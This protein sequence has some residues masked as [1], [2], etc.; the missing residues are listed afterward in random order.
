M[1]NRHLG[2]L[3]SKLQS[4]VLL[5]LTKQPTKKS[6]LVNQSL[7]PTSALN[8]K[9]QS[10]LPNPWHFSDKHLRNKISQ[11]VTLFTLQ[12]LDSKFKFPLH[13]HF[14]QRLNFSPIFSQFFSRMCWKVIN[15]QMFG[16]KAKHPVV[17]DGYNPKWRPHTENFVPN[18]ATPE[19]VADAKTTVEP[20]KIAFA[21]AALC[22]SSN[23]NRFV[24]TKIL[25][26]EISFRFL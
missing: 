13:W 5:L 1:S 14:E 19:W 11:K 9:N 25:K 3:R 20:K 10:S 23:W 12:S 4:L 6:L 15:E 7:E 17:T 16:H 24:V 21:A 18:D 22:H 2:W 26:E 8:P